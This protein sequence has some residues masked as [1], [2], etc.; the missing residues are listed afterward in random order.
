MQ[1]G[2]MVRERQSNMT[3]PK[4]TPETERTVLADQVARS[5]G[6]LA[7]ARK[8]RPDHQAES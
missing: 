4:C 5:R 2:V 7:R 1:T 8:E 6:V 3:R